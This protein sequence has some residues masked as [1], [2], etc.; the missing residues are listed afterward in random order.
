MHRGL[1]LTVVLPCHNEEQ[2]V[3]AVIRRIPPVVDEILVV[4]NLCT[5]RTAEVARGCGARVVEQRIKGY[6]AAYQAGMAAATGDVIITMDADG[7]YP[8]EEVPRLVDELVDRRLDFLSACRFPLSQP[9]A[10]PVTNRIG[11]RALTLALVVL[12]GRVIR[13]S[14]SGMWVFRRSILDRVRPTSHGM[15]FSEEIK[16]E[17]LTNGLRF[18]ESH[19]PY[20]E[21]VGETKLRAWRDGWENLRFLVRRRLG[22][23]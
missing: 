8:P 14:Q 4:D 19:I 22:R 20:G 3:A 2:G 15:P 10:M 1:R 18:A 5:D 13:D 12:Y 11:N 17:A 21:R 9:K 23:R 16:I 6:G 7:S